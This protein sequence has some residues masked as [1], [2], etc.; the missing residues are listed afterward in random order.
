MHITKVRVEG[1]KSFLDTTEL[2]L[3]PGINVIVGRNG[4]GKSNL[5]EAIA[6]IMQMRPLSAKQRQ[7]FT[8]DGGDSRAGT[9]AVEITLDNTSQRIPNQVQYLFSFAKHLSQSHD[10]FLPLV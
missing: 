9:A 10:S 4:S 6:L 8:H 5:V 3:H 1:F 7:A 2:E